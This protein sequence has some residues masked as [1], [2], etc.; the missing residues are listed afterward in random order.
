VPHYAPQGKGKRVVER[1]PLS[2]RKRRPALGAEVASAAR[3]ASRVRHDLGEQRAKIKMPARNDALHSTTTYYL[4]HSDE[5]NTHGDRPIEEFEGSHG[6]YSCR[7]GGVLAR[8]RRYPVN[9]AP[10][11]DADAV[12]GKANRF[13]AG[14]P[15]SATAPATGFP[16]DD[17]A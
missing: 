1:H 4:G 8:L 14:R 2:A 7:V 15:V 17:S 6:S 16:V 5:T 13:R 9:D 11:P 10:P 12:V 3:G